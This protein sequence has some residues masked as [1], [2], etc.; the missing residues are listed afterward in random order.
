MLPD[1]VTVYD[2]PREYGVTKYRY[3]VVNDQTV[4]IDPTTHRIV[5][6]IG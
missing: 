6:I 5:E 3:S 4:L 1:T 2:V